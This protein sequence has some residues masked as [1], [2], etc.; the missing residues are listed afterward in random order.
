[1]GTETADSRYCSGL[2]KT[3]SL[4][5]DVHYNDM[6]L[7]GTYTGGNRSMKQVHAVVLAS[8]LAAGPA[9]GGSPSVWKADLS[10]SRVEFN[11]SHLVISE[12]TGRFTDFEVTLEQGKDDFS[13]ST[14]EASIQTKS[15]NTD[16]QQRDNHLRSDDFLNSEKFP[17]LKFKSSSFEKTGGNEYKITGDLTIRDVTR[18]VVLDGKLLGSVKTPWGDERAGF[19]ATTSVNRFDYGVR[20]DKTLDSGGLVAGKDVAITLRVELV[21]QK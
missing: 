9:L 17:E 1:M 4:P 5:Y 19:V 11:V 12:V 16:N 2:R 10:H 6:F 13:G 14:V 21:K 8:M 18:T 3:G 20:W 15:I 7:Q